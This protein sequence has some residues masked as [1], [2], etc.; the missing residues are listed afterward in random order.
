[1]RHFR[2]ALVVFPSFAA[3]KSKPQS[4]AGTA[5]QAPPPTVTGAAVVA[6]TPFKLTTR[7]FGIVQGDFVLPL[8]CFD[9]KT[10][11]ILNGRDCGALLPSDA[12]GRVSDRTVK[13]S[14]GLLEV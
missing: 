10:A 2:Y 1:M 14:G 12:E 13:V 7:V 11:R 6:D 4:D 9:G 3:C 5:T 8:A